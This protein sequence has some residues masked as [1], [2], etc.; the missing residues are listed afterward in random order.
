MVGHQV[1]NAAS[2]GSLTTAII[3]ANV[4]I[5][6]SIPVVYME[7]SWLEVDVPFVYEVF[8]LVG[9]FLRCDRLGRLLN[10]EAVFTVMLGVPDEYTLLFLV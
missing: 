10:P 8:W 1:T 3:L 7:A 4:T 5:K 9:G 6:S 2:R